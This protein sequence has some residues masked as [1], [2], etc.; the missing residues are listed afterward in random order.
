MRLAS[1]VC[2][3]PLLVL[4]PGAWADS[5]ADQVQRLDLERGGVEWEAQ[6]VAARA[7]AD[8]DSAQ[9]LNIA[10]EYGL[11]DALGVGF[12]LNG[13][14]SG[15]AAFAAEQFALQAKLVAL[16]P[17]RAPVGLGA[18]ISLG[19]AFDIGAATA[20]VR[21][22]AERR[23]GAFAFAGDVQIEAEHS[24][25]DAF[26]SWRAEWRRGWGLIGVEAGGELGPLDAIAISGQRSHWLGPVL[27]FGLGDNAAL[28]F[29]AFAALSDAAPDLQSRIAIAFDL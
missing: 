6:T 5:L 22:L 11:S 19:R 17:A 25:T 27:E 13:A 12:E 26:Y 15:G 29:S 7:S 9:T 14:R 16:D 4:A 10:A 28:E 2:A 1:I 23:A 18:Q 24:E 8:A 3:A 20:E 21:L